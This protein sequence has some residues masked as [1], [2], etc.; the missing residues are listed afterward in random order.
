VAWSARAASAQ[1]IALLPVLALTA[2]LIAVEAL[3]PWPLKVLVD[4][5][6]SGEEPTGVIGAILVRLPGAESA[7]GLIAW[8]VAATV[9]LFL[10][11]WAATTGAAVATITLSQRMT[12]DL[13]TEVFEHL[14]RMS[15]V[16]HSRRRTGDLVRR[17]SADTGSLATIV[18]AAMLPALTAMLS[19]VTVLLIMWNLDRAL[20]LMALGIIPLLAFTI[21]RF[22][23]PMEQAGYALGNA[24][25]D[26]YTATEER[27]STVPAIQ[28]F[29]RERDADSVVWRAGQS[30][31]AASL[32]A[33]RAQVDFKVVV[34]VVGALGTAGI[35]LAGGW[36]AL[37]GS[38]T[39]GTMLV[40]ISYVAALYT[41]LAAITYS[42]AAVLQ[43]AGGAQ[44][45]HELLTERP[46]VEDAPDAYDLPEISGRIDFRNVTA[47]YY[48]DRPV[49]KN[50][51]LTVE[52][53][54]FVALVGPSGAGK[55]T[56]INLIPR[57]MDP[58]EGSIQIDG[59][60]LC[61]VTLA[62]LRRQI[63][64]VPQDPHLL[65]LSIAENIAFGKPDASRPDIVAA[66]K[67]A[68]A[69]AFIEE[70]P[71]GYETIAG[72]RGATLS[73]GQRQRVAIARALLLD[74]PIL[75]LDEPTSALDPEM[76]AE[77]LQALM[78]RVGIAT[79]LLISHRPGVHDLAGRTVRIPDPRSHIATSAL[80]T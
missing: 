14:Q 4:N 6:L 22:A 13:A 26:L 42:S 1:W 2:L 45:V 25:G 61:S 66:A 79:T 74:P 73:G 63:G 56:L 50:L 19:L 32:S 41:P 69:H 53:G 46:D 51:D 24:Y 36:Q 21:W 59:H 58:W 35:L 70:L 47:G 68:R 20:T 9:L 52:A 71:H 30:T 54:E 49:L 31:L 27:L 10:A 8:S 44:R 72:E 60:E 12:Y 39:V 43:A 23:A 65:P 15:P 64:V 38:V 33:T 80:G 67:L 5:G 40:F 55:T 77:L 11:S 76:E 18:V 17:L 16:Y 57:F 62:S 75:I 48:E 28:A 78:R 7:D 29:T 3:K 37:D 34:G